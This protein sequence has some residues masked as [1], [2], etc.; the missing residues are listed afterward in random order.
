MSDLRVL[1]VDDEPAARRGLRRLLEADPGVVI[2]GEARH[3]REA[4]ERITSL[5]PDVVFLDIQMP[6][7]NGFEVIEALADTQLPV[8]V[9]VTAYDDWA[10]QAFEVQALDYILKPYEDARVRTALER[11][12]GHLSNLSGDVVEKVRALVA[13][14]PPE[15]RY[16]TRLIV[17]EAGIVQFVPLGDVDWFEAADYYVRVHSGKQTQLVRYSLNELER[18]LDPERYVRVHRSAIVNVS[19]VLEIR[20]AH[21]NHHELVLRDNTRVPLSRGRKE[22]LE[23][24]LSRTP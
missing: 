18:Q 21:H 17:R 23:S 12:R 13:E 6:E 4:V 7:L 9:F 3:G 24:I 8:I 16:L 1:V 10:V 15:K 2:V 20:I 5:E 22:H 11:V 14:R 19:A